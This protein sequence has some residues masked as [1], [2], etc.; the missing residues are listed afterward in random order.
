MNERKIINMWPLIYWIWE[1][2]AIY[3]YSYYSHLYKLHLV[4]QQLNSQPTG[5]YLNVI[6]STYSQ[7]PISGEITDIHDRIKYCICYI[8]YTLEIGHK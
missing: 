1:L 6:N 8:W 2:G 3:T 5:A 7:I 4:D